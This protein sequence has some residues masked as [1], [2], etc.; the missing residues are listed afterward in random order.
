M[1]ACIPSRMQDGPPLHPMT[2]LDLDDPRAVGRGTC[3]SGGC[4]QNATVESGFG[5]DVQNSMRCPTPNG[6][7]AC[8]NVNLSRGR[9]EPSSVHRKDGSWR[10][11]KTLGHWEGPSH[12]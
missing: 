5:R 11:P 10:K 9:V 4:M 8:Q 7:V 6:I 12:V 1:Q 3:S 2:R